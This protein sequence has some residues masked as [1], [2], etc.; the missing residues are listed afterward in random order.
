MKMRS[1]R[2]KDKTEALA[3]LDVVRIEERINT[4]K[5]RSHASY[6]K[7]PSSLESVG[8]ARSA[9]E[10]AF[11]QEV[12]KR[13]KAIQERDYF[14]VQLDKLL[15]VAT[16]AQRQLVA[17]IPEPYIPTDEEIEAMDD[18]VS[19]Y[20]SYEEMEEKAVRFAVGGS[21]RRVAVDSAQPT[22]EE[23]MARIRRMEETGQYE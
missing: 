18:D 2:N 12:R 23:L 1:M 5:A 14:E 4:T 6:K 15:A 13:E 19:P 22:T 16:P 9:G 3:R 17:D 7:C 10:F 21:G 8:S 20:L 11:R